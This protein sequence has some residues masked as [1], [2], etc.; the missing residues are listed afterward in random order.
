MSEIIDDKIRA[1][2]WLWAI[3][4]FKTRTLATDACNAGKVKID[5]D[6]IK[7]SRMLKVGD[8]LSVQ[9]EQEKKI[10]RVVT[11]IEKRVGAPQAMMCYDD[12]SPKTDPSEKLDPL[13]YTIAHRDRGAGR[14]TKKERRALDDYFDDEPI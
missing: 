13:F 7:A 3:R 5:G 14:P 9:R 4:M 2:K 12:L 10:I 1:D 11:L 6:S 8:L